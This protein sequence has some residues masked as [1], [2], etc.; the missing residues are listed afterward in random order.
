MRRKFTLVTQRTWIER[1]IKEVY[2]TNSKKTKKSPKYNVKSSLV[3][4]NKSKEK[5]LSTSLVTMKDK[6]NVKVVNHL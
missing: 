3:N 2:M 6:K 4:K 1:K 5:E